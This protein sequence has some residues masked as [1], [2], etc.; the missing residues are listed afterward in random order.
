M[1]TLASEMANRGHEVYFITFRP[2][3]EDFFNV[4]ENISRI[5][6]GITY[7]DSVKGIGYARYNVFKHMFRLRKL[8]TNISP[9]YIV[10]A[11]SSTN[12]FVLLATIFSGFKVVITEHIHF[13]APPDFWKI[14]RAIVYRNCHKL[15]VLTQRDKDKFLSIVDDNKV[16]VIS[17][18]LTI[19][20]DGKTKPKIYN[21]NINFLS[22]GRF[23]EQKG[24]D[25]LINAFVLVVEK[26]PNAHLTLVGDGELLS[27]MQLLAN[28][29]GVG[30]N[31]K[32]VG[33]SSNVAKYYSS[34]DIYVMSSRFEGF[35]LVLTEAM[36]FGLPVISFDCPTGPRE[37]LGNSEYGILVPEGDYH[38]LAKSMVKLASDSDLFYFYSNKSVCR[39]K[40]YSIGSISNI[41]EKSVFCTS[42]N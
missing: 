34:H 41:W 10:S 29:L 6:L 22:I 23:T 8:L 16:E 24:F 5:D 28:K 31:I 30:N 19:K 42:N 35:G 7:S 26:L 2:S 1:L 9:D 40:D 3:N 33:R 38:N 20:N 14:L 13:D 32:F 25:L 4:P 12:I 21:E 15:V 27:D 37:I 18:P 39:Y 11:W 17:N 36:S